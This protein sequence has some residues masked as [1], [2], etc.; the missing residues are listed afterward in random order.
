MILKAISP[1]IRTGDLKGTIAFYEQQ[2]GFT[3]A[4][5]SEEWAWAALRRDDTEIMVS[6]LREEDAGRPAFTGSFYFR[7]DDGV[8][9]LW[10]ELKDKATICYPVETFA[11][12]MREF[13]V[14]DNNGYLLQFGQEVAA[15]STE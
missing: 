10:A 4:A 1:V 2:L 5:Y 12:G 11:Y 3:C 13:A 15:A 7:L 6:A 9:D 14:F 8:D